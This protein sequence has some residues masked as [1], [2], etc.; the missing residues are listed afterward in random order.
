MHDVPRNVEGVEAAAG[1]TSVAIFAHPTVTT[2]DPGW[3][4]CPMGC[5]QYGHEPPCTVD[6]PLRLSCH[7]CGALDWSARESLETCRDVCPMRAVA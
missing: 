6:R 1:G 4:G 3:T 5:G 2:V 7:A